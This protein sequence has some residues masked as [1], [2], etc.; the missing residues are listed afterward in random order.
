MAI[1]ELVLTAPLR[2]KH[3]FVDVQVLEVPVNDYSSYTIEAGLENN[4]KETP[5][6]W[7]LVGG[8]VK[9]ACS[10]DI[11]NRSIVAGFWNRDFG[12]MSRGAF[13]TGAFTASQVANLYLAQPELESF[14]VPY[15]ENTAAAHLGIREGWIMIGREYFMVSFSGAVIADIVTMNLRFKHLNRF[16]EMK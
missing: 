15:V 14:M 7:E 1:K 11:A 12:W 13:A 2:K 5:N 8:T 4:N 16:M 3:P 6:I 9:L 10:A